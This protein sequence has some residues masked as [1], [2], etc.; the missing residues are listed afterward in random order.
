M[1]A[2]NVHLPLFDDVGP[3]HSQWKAK[4]LPNISNEHNKYPNSQ[5]KSKR[6]INGVYMKQMSIISSRKKTQSPLAAPAILQQPEN[7]R[8]RRRWPS[9]SSECTLMSNLIIYRLSIVSEESCLDDITSCPAKP[10][11][12]FARCTQNDRSSFTYVKFRWS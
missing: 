7:L 6:K 2:P 5:Y 8:R 12:A 9:L 1:L 10:M 4:G 11:R 3:L